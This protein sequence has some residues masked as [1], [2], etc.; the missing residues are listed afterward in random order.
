MVLIGLTSYFHS[1]QKM[2]HDPGDQEEVQ[3]KKWNQTPSTQQM[4]H[5][6]LKRF[7]K[8]ICAGMNNKAQ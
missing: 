3:V 6:F 1:K 2:L 8:T 7:C 5:I 4:R